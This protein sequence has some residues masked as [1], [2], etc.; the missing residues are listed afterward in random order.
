M[1]AVA[2]N[3]VEGRGGSSTI[4]EGDPLTAAAAPEMARRDSRGG[5]LLP[6]IGPDERDAVALFLNLST[7][8]KHVGMSAVRSGIDYAVVPTVAAMLG[9][10]TGPAMLADLRAM[11]HE[12]LVRMAAQ[13]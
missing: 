6:E 5:D 10:A 4:E 2:R 12:A 13:S 7:Q 9:I 3:W 11:E 1:R 8:W